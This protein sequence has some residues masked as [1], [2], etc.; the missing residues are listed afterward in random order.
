MQVRLSKETE[1]ELNRATRYFNSK[2]A[3]PKGDVFTRKKKLSATEI[4][5]GL[6]LHAL[7]KLIS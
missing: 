1:K 5:N 3:V 4:A 7:Q 6:I 2:E